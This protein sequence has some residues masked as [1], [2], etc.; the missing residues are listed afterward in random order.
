[1]AVSVSAQAQMDRTFYWIIT[2]LS[3][4]LGPLLWC[5]LLPVFGPRNGFAAISACLA[6]GAIILDIWPVPMGLIVAAVIFGGASM[7]AVVAAA[8]MVRRLIPASAFVTGVCFIACVFILGQAGG[9]L[10]RHYV[11]QTS[12]S[13]TALW[14]APMCLI[15]AALVA[16]AGGAG[17][18]SRHQLFG[19]TRFRR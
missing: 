15:S 8:L 14:V 12:G 13:L 11:A 9:L 3:C 2:G 7:A 4:L 5:R 6:C 18:P 16:G 17:N 10:V 1:M 19:L